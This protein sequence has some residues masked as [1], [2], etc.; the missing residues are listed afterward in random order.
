MDSIE[1][2]PEPHRTETKVMPNFLHIRSGKKQCLAEML[3]RV[4]KRRYYTLY[5]CSCYFDGDAARK[6]IAELQAF[7]RISGVKIY[8]DRR[9]AI[10]YGGDYLQEFCDSFDDFEVIINAVES[11]NLFHSK[12]YSLI[13]FD[14]DDRVSGSIVLGSA[15]LTGAGLIRRGGNFECLLDSQD[16]EILEQHLS[17][18]E[19]L[20]VLSPQKLNRFS[21]REEF[22]FKYALLQYGIFVHKWNDNLEQYLSIRYRLTENGKSRITDQS[23]EDAGFN[24]ETAT[25]SKRYFKFDYVPDHLDNT[26]NVLRNYGIETYLGHWLPYSVSESMFEA[27]ALNAFKEHLFSEIE[28]QGDE[29]EIKIKRDYEYLLQKGL[30]EEPEVNPVDSFNGKINSLTSNELKLKRIYSRYELFYLPFDIQQKE[31]II[32]LFDEM[33]NVAESRRRRNRAMRAFLESYAAFSLDRFDE[34]LAEA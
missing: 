8:I 4:D 15:N 25:I 29:I 6:L 33:V 12:V 28:R 2:T 24:I 7:V 26:E 23:L 22:S 16:N 9:A 10:E 18:L 31:D 5:L 17:Q 30:I 34:A 3:G 32:Y 20:K 19:K 27:D 11:S 14:D 21:R 1:H 13:A